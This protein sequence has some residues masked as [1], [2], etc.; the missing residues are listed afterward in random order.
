[1]DENGA[2]DKLGIRNGFRV[3]SLVL[4]LL[5]MVFALSGVS[6]TPK[7]NLKRHPGPYFECLI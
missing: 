6:A 5:I 1:M 3:W 4:S 2:V 7:Q